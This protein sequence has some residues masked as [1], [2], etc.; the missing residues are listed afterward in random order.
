MSESGSGNRLEDPACSFQSGMLH[1]LDDEVLADK[2]LQQFG[3]IVSARI[4][5]NEQG[6][7][8]GFG[9]VSYQSP[10]Q[11][12][13]WNIFVLQATSDIAFPSDPSTASNEW[14]NSGIETDCG[15]IT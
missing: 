13:F 7:S 6:Q 9:F 3:N 2:K 10:E 8:R 11:G 5:R 1:R 14:C 15:S 12:N 4:M